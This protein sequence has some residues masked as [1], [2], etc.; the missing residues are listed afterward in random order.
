[1]IRK[2]T[3]SKNKPKGA[4]C[5]AGKCELISTGRLHVVSISVYRVSSK[6]R[7]LHH[8]KQINNLHNKRIMKLIIRNEPVSTR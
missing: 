5:H 7:I 1:M 4:G 6:N 2:Y 3:N 8:K